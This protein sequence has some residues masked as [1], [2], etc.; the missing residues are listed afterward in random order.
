[1]SYH[2]L[3][4]P[5]FNPALS[6]EE[7]TFSA[8]QYACKAFDQ[9]PIILRNLIFNVPDQTFKSFEIDFLVVTEARIFIV[10]SKHF[11]GRITYEGGATILNTTAQ[12]TAE[13]PNPLGQNKDK[14][15]YLREV[16]PDLS[17]ASI[18]VVSNRQAEL[19][20]SV[21]ANLLHIT[22]LAYFMRLKA[23]E[24][25]RQLKRRCDDPAKL[26]FKFPLGGLSLLETAELFIALSNQTPEAF[27][28][29]VA[30][31]REYKAH[32]KPAV[33]ERP[34]EIA[35]RKLIDGVHRARQAGQTDDWISEV[36]S[37]LVVSMTVPT[38]KP[39]LPA[40]S[41]KASP[42]TSQAL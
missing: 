38:D 7:A 5:H 18:S 12:G 39:L 26:R 10:E 6:G 4:Q 14:M 2:H 1:M 41:P 42:L 11:S 35:R 20:Q 36:L 28:E 24:Y 30:F 25:R 23:D 40:V 34:L 3:P 37:S 27:T 16:L 22:D 15:Q 9:P 8:L 32:R 17:F 13:L 31:C 29:H 33:L 21:P 19:T